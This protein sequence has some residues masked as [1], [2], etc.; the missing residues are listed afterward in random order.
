MYYTVTEFIYF[1]FAGIVCVSLLLF[2]AKSKGAVSS[3]RMGIRWRDYLHQPFQSRQSPSNARKVIPTKTLI[4]CEL[5]Y[6]KFVFGSTSYLYMYQSTSQ[7]TWRR[8]LFKGELV[9]LTS[10]CP[11]LCSD[12]LKPASNQTYYVKNMWKLRIVII[13]I[14][15]HIISSIFYV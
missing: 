3:L 5:G 14:L 6:L 8:F 15:S 10:L 9:C 4:L 11:D 1:Q 2:Q 7:A 13:H 12:C